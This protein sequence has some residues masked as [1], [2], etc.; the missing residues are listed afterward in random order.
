MLKLEFK[1][2]KDV[3][4]KKAVNFRI[5]AESGKKIELLNEK[6]LT[7]NSPNRNTCTRY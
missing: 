1:F 5:L 3:T 7:E 2:F 4:L 6:T